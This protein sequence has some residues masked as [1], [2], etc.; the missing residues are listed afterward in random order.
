MIPKSLR[1]K[2]SEDPF[3][4]KCSYKNCGKNTV[5]WHHVYQF[6]DK[7]IQEE[8][9]IVPACPKHHH[10]ATPH[11]NAYRQEVREYFEWVS[12]QKMSLEDMT[13]YSKF[14]DLNTWMIRRNYLF[15]KASEYGW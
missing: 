13:K 2:L 1:K 4:E 10:Q 12:L 8:F 9:N 6:A 14:N 3:M 15:M 5:E 11:N 7:S